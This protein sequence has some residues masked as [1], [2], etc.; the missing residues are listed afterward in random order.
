[1]ARHV[2]QAGRFKIGLDKPKIMGIV[3]LTPDSLS[4]GGAYSQ[5]AQT[6]LA[7]A[8]RLL[9]EGADILDIGGEST[10]P[11]ADY[12][13]PE[14]EWARVEPVLAEVAGWGVPV[15]LDTRRTVVMEKA[16]AL[17]GIDIINDVAALTDEG[18]VELLARQADT[19]ICLM[20]MRGLPETM[21]DNPKYQDVVGEVARYLKTRSETCVAAGIAPQRITLDPGF[22]FGKNLQH[23]IALMRHL[24]ELMA[25]TGLPLLIGVSRKSM[26]GEL[27]GEADA[28]ARVHGSVAAALASVARGAQIV[29]VHDVKATADAL[30]VWEALG[31]NR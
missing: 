8:E 12:V 14:E 21:Q 25:E 5:N 6:A 2:W 19:G 22:G 23:N 4:D 29:R 31:V 24:P 30:K 9:K 1:M 26:I 15:S 7:H 11:G 16:L 18:A 3:N 27:T 10:R 17:G 13:S 20:H 28:A